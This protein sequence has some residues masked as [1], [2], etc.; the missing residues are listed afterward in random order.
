MSTASKGLRD[1][2]KQIFSV[3]GQVPS[4][5]YVNTGCL[6]RIAD[7]LE[8]VSARYLSLL[9]EVATFKRWYEDEVKKRKALE[10]SNSALRGQITKLK[11]KL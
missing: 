9:S 8:T 1:T 5:E 2:S 10:R 11:A 3:N 4:L 7:S 6:Q